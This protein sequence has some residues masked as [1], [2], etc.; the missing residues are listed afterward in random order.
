MSNELRTKQCLATV[1]V[2]HLNCCT[3]TT[4]TVI[5]DDLQ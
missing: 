1:A 4:S 3:V 5:K 2:K